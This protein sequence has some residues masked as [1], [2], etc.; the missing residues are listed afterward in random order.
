MILRFAAIATS[1][2]FCGAHAAT[3]LETTQLVATTASADAQAP[4]EIVFTVQTEGSYTLTLTDLQLPAALANVRAIVTNDLE[5]VAD[6]ALEGGSNATS[7]S[8][9]FTATPGVYR[10]LV[11]GEADEVEGAGTYGV[12]V[13]PA[14]GGAALASGSGSF[15]TDS[16][17]PEGV[18]V[19]EA[20]VS[21]TQ[22]GS[23]DLSIVDHGFPAALSR[24]QAAVFGPD[25]ALAPSPV[26][27]QTG[28]STATFT[29]AQT[30]QHTLRVISTAATPQFSG[31]YSV[32]INLSGG[33]QVY[34]S[35]QPVGRLSPAIAVTAP[36]AGALTVVREDASFPEGL[37]SHGVAVA[38]NGALLSTLSGDGASDVVV[39]AGSV[40]LF[41]GGSAAQVGAVSLR[42]SQGAQVL[43]SDVVP[44]DASSD[45]ASTA[46]YT[47][48]AP[49]PVVAG[50]YRLTLQDFRFPVQF[51]ALDAA[52]VQGDQVLEL[53]DGSRTR[54]VAL[55]AGPVKVLVAARAT[56]PGAQAA[57]SALFGVTLTSQPGGAEVLATTQ[58]VGGLFRSL[59]V[60][61]PTDG[62]YDV[63]LVDLELPARLRTS[64]IAIT[65][66]TA[67]VGQIFGG[68]VLGGQQL[69]SGQY[70][71][72][73]I[74]QPAVDQ[75]YGAYGLKIADSAPRPTITFSATPTSITSGQR[76]TLQW[77]AT[78]ATAC[79]ASGGWTGQKS[80]SGSE[81]S[82][83]LNAN[84]S[85][86]LTCS[87]P[88]GSA[89]ATASVTV[90]PPSPNRSNGGGGAVGALLLIYMSTVLLVRRR[91]GSLA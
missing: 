12:Q 25:G 21:I 64:A 85:F 36:A 80:A 59:L 69:A 51:N 65:R 11:S 4:R 16:G 40:Q 72:N 88:G 82:A 34:T 73:F 53:L 81:Q 2:L 27:T 76:A 5:V 39:G 91:A 84:T 26:D 33:A 22:A 54:D 1:L 90:S 41:A 66:G 15:V 74:G 47:I 77:N 60:Q 8:D 58:G 32:R 61:I 70:V 68:G 42:V 79:T 56:A 20:T 24:V 18:S 37:L 19:F 35:V 9:A 63:R 45:A 13:T 83:V 14:A 52:V 30:G 44:I 62:P 55:A 46:I 49:Q 48:S 86:D 75:E 7:A 29:V 89:S 87:G 57:Q 71:V 3:V 50:A 78:N 28:A 17:A 43:Y 67:L 10:I 38:Q 23:Y 6:A 31:L